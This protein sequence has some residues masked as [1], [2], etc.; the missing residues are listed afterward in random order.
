METM[1]DLRTRGVGSVLNYS[2]EADLEGVEDSGEFMR[3]LERRRLKEV[4][5]AL[6]QAGEFEMECER[7]GGLRGSTAF[8]LKVVGTRLV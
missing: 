1:R 3:E 4:E 7:N 8:A 5:R 2:A 6:D